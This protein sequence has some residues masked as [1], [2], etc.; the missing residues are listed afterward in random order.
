MKGTLTKNEQT[1]S[2]AYTVDETIRVDSSVVPVAASP[3]LKETLR[4]GSICNN[5]RLNEEGN[6]I[7]QST[8]VALL[9]VLP[10][11]GMTD[12]R[13]V[14]TLPCHTAAVCSPVYRNSTAP[15]SAHS[16]QSRSSWL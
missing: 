5:A 6:L 11:F 2:E 16:I 14:S 15:W 12:Q 8:D 4:I 1:V 3:A 9:E 7:G 13:T 10:L